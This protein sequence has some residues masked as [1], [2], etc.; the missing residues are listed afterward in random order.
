MVHNSFYNLWNLQFHKLQLFVLQSGL[1]L[2]RKKI[3]NQHS[4]LLFIQITNSEF[5]FNHTPKCHIHNDSL[6]LKH[7][8]TATIILIRLHEDPYIP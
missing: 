3:G 7:S 4:V 5:F 2:Q 6:L 8:I 1:T